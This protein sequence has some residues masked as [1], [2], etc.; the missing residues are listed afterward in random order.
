MTK[1]EQYAMD[2]ATYSDVVRPTQP[3]LH[4]DSGQLLA[5]V[6]DDGNVNVPFH[7]YGPSGAV[8]LAEFI[9]EYYTEPT[10]T[11]EPVKTMR[12]N[13]AQALA[14]MLAGKR[15]TRYERGTLAG[16]GWTATLDG[17]LTITYGGRDY[18]TDAM[19][20][21]ADPQVTWEVVG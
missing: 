12:L 2:M 4:D 6:C 14:A 19:G 13:G 8:K 21:L 18:T 3:E 11:P 7:Y 1:A 10:P 20:Y 5:C 17:P 9:R 15:L 16:R